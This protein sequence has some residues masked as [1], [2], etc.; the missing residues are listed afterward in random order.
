M[1]INDRANST[2]TTATTNDSLLVLCWSGHSL[3]SSSVPIRPSQN[4]WA[5]DTILMTFLFSQY[6]FE[7]RQ[8]RRQIPTHTTKSDLDQTKASSHLT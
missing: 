5:I 8:V 3:F 7:C 1:L 4:P 2:E 6:I